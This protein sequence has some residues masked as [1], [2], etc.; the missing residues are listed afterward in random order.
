MWHHVCV[1]QALTSPAS[2]LASCPASVL[3][4]YC[5]HHGRNAA[6]RGRE[7]RRLPGHIR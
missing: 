1:V 4:S 5:C 7:G 3:A 6:I 2:L